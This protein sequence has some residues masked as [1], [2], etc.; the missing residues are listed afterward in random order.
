MADSIEPRLGSLHLEDLAIVA[1]TARSGASIVRYPQLDEERRAR[2]R[3][4]IK[5]L[6]RHNWPTS[7]GEDPMLRR[8]YTLRQCC[9]LLVALQML[10]AHIVPSLA[11]PIASANEWALLRYMVPQMVRAGK[12]AEGS[13]LPPSSAIAVLLLGELVATV[14]PD[15]WQFAQPQQLRFVPEVQVAELWSPSAGLA[16]A[17]QRLALDVGTAAAAAWRWLLDRDLMP[18]TTLEQ[19]AA[20]VDQASELPGYEAKPAISLRR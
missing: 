9:R 20:D 8:G 6:S 14:A 13:R 17:G 16:H 7:T 10:D 2:L 15:V 18:P 3:A 19:L 12:A 11:V 4:R 1:L 5:Q